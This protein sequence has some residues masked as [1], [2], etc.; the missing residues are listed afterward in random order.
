MLTII[1]F[2]LYFNRIPNHVK[3][4]SDPNARYSVYTYD[5]IPPNA[6]IG[7]EEIDANFC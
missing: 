1:V 7:F 3:F 6:I 2:C 4:Y 5:N